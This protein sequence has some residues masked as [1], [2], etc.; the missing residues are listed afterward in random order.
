[1][2][3]SNRKLQK[4]NRQRQLLRA[5][6][7][8]RRGVLLLVVLSILILFLLIGTTFI[9]TAGQHKDRA[10]ILEKANRTT[11]QPEDVLERALMQ[12]V[13]DTNNRHSAL[14]Y[15]SLLRDVYG[16]DG[17]VGQVLMSG[18]VPVRED[19]DGDGQ[20][21]SVITAPRFAGPEDL[22]PNNDLTNGQLVDLYV[23]DA[24]ID[25]RF[26]PSNAVGLDL[27]SNGLPINYS[28]SLNSAY[29]NGCLL[30]L[31]EGPCRGMSV[32][33]VDYDT[34][35]PTD[36][37]TINSQVLGRLRVMVPQRLDGSPISVA[38]DGSLPEFYD[39]S[40]V[41]YRF[42]VNGRPHNGTGVGFNAIT[43]N[44]DAKLTALEAIVDP[45]S[46]IAY[47]IE[48][49]LAP[50]S[51]YFNQNGLQYL[52]P[53]LVD[54]S[55]NPITSPFN[56]ELTNVSFNDLRDGNGNSLYPNFPGP[57][58]TDESYDAPD[59]QNMFLAHQSLTPRFRGRLRNPSNGAVIDPATYGRQD[60]APDLINLK[61]VTI[62]SLHRPALANFWFH[63]LFNSDWLSGLSELERYQAILDPYGNAW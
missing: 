1:M 57:G 32:R 28:L 2:K 5:R 52:V 51:T 43:D 18:P 14:R 6:A 21:D 48:L 24:L 35:I 54:S 31:M 19:F 16:G 63:R 53:G 42:I 59:F 23:Q 50:N 11:F 36:T 47:G 45:A 37:G 39:N 12:L 58:D 20:P 55:L 38:S 9:L 15:H 4:N 7:S 56:G 29:Y 8:D 27:D 40:G 25:D 44:D 60:N 62:P 46:G 49:A 26:D 30:T 34:Y 41:G 33:I 10:K 17:F 61:N 3:K 22:L 13:R